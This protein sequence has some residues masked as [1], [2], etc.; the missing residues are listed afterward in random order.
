MIVDIPNFAAGDGVGYCTDGPPAAGVE[1]YGGSEGGGWERAGGEAAGGCAFGY[2]WGGWGVVEDCE[3]CCGVRVG[4]R[5]GA[6]D[7]ECVVQ[8]ER[9]GSRFV[10]FCVEDWKLISV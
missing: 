8:F 5:R 1:E 2:R 10:S 6:L 7:V 3:V 4:V 9:R